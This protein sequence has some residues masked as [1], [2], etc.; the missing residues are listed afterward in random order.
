MAGRYA[1]SSD[2]AWA[3][4]NLSLVT[5]GLGSRGAGDKPAFLTEHS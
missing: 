3:S 5:I 2:F 4:L 1:P